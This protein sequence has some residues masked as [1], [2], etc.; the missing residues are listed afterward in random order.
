M[1]RA[2][3]IGQSGDGVAANSKTV[4]EVTGSNEGTSE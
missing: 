4:D 1:T 3:N 2:T